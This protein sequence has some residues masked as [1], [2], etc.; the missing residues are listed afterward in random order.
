VSGQH[1]ITTFA[2]TLDS[3]GRVCIPASWRQVLA[4]QNTTGV[5]VAASLNGDSL[6]GFG[7]EL[8]AA[9]L[10]RLDALDPVYSQAH[11][12]LSHLVS[13]SWQLP[14]DENGRVRLPDDLIAAAGL[15]DRVVFVGMGKKFEIWNPETFA[16]REVAARSAPIPGAA[17]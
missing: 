17:S 13:N 9:E 4:T 16:A 10:Q 5:Y 14:I 7:E 6:L 8:M 15:K 11:D 12:D 3:K 1:F 2:G